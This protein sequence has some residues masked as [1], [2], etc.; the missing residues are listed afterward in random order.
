MAN[1]TPKMREILSLMNNGATLTRTKASKYYYA[2]SWL[3]WKGPND[4]IE[5]LEVS[6]RVVTLLEERGYLEVDWPNAM[7]DEWTY[8]LT[9]AGREA[10]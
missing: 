2:G 3:Q 4:E 6:S 8:N 9:D 10:L 1:L 5:D 7:P